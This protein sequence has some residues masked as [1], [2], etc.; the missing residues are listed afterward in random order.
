MKQGDTKEETKEFKKEYRE[1]YFLSAGETGAEQEMA[2]TLLVSKLIDIATAHANHL[3]IGNPYMKDKNCGWV[4]SRLTVEMRCYPR[5]NDTYSITTWVES[6]N[7]HYSERA[8]C[9]EDAEG[10]PIGYARS[11]WM[12]L[13]TE[14]RANAGLE[15]LILP[16]GIISMRDCPIERQAKHQ[17]LYAPGEDAPSA[18]ALQADAAPGSYRFSYCDLDAYRHVNTVRYVAL[19]MNQFSL[20]EHDAMR[21]ARFELS[22][23]HE[24]AYGMTVDVLRSKIAD[25]A[26][27]ESGEEKP[28]NSY[29]FMLRN[30]DG[31]T[32]ILYSRV[33]MLPRR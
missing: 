17:L 30:N 3:K 13:D 19:L 16:E 26:Q 29:A 14:T 21:V 6:W 8:F 25:S 4:L 20:T 9:I 24:G 22:F 12:V 28:G 1:T 32:P 15:H 27:R 7:R 5:V 33:F 18:K 31:N 11:I 10:N 23:L 2:Q